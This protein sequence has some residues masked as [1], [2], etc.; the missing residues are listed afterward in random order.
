MEGNEIMKKRVLITII[1]CSISIGLFGC[2]E[3]KSEQVINKNIQDETNNSK[4]EDEFYLYKDC[5]EDYNNRPNLVGNVKS[6]LKFKLDNSISEKGYLIYNKWLTEDDLSNITSFSQ[7]EDLLEKNGK[8]P[9]TREVIKIHLDEKISEPNIVLNRAKD[10]GEWL[11]K[12]NFKLTNKAKEYSFDEMDLWNKYILVIA[13]LDGLALNSTEDTKFKILNYM[14]DNFQNIEHLETKE[15]VL[16]YAYLNSYLQNAF[17]QADTS[18]DLFLN[19]LESVIRKKLELIHTSN[20]IELDEESIIFNE[21]L[22]RDYL[23]L[24]Y[25]YLE[26]VKSLK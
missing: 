16:R 6:N 4:K 17:I 25:K 11:P 13:K 1:L 2:S 8:F 20:D 22:R 3:K 12:Q 24:V 14:I 7:I 18:V 26:E 23:D 21:S 10:I 9:S 19:N 5:K 15:E